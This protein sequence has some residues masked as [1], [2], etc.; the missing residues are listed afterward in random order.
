MNLVEYERHVA[1]T[2]A[3][4]VADTTTSGGS[5]TTAVCARLAR[6]P[7]GWFRGWEF[8]AEAL[9]EKAAVTA[10]T[11][12]SGT[13]TFTPAITSV[14]TSVKFVLVKQ[15]SID[16][17]ERLVLDAIAVRFTHFQFP[18]HNAHFAKVFRFRDDRLLHAVRD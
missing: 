18:L 2:L 8:F 9:N 10:F 14:A 12:S 11:S 3:D 1:V 7:D 5:T 16:A 15:L 17:I 13:L 4:G 6:Y